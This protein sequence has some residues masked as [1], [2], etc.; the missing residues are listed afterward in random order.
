MHSLDRKKILIFGGS[1]FLGSHLCIRLAHAHRT[2]V[3]ITDRSAVFKLIKSG[4]DIV[5]NLAGIS[6][7]TVKEPSTSFTVNVIGSLNILE[8]CRRA[9][10]KPII[11]FSNSRQEYGRPQYLPVGE[12]HPT[13]PTNLYGVYKLAVTHLAQLYHRTYDLPTIVFRTSNVYGPSSSKTNNYNIINQWLS[14]KPITI[15]GTGSQKRDYLFIDD[16]I[17][18][19]IAA[20]TTPKAYGQIFNIGYGQGRTLSSMAKTIAKFT[21]AKLINQPWPPDWQSVETG[22]YISDIFK[23]RRVLHWQPSNE[24]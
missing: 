12:N 17:D 15:F 14:G 10:I 20:L 7:I 3:D 18:A 24:K 13:N 6:G 2:N 8:A 11:F 4:W 21:G 23:A 9:K 1:G 22:S 5:I 16:W 19:V